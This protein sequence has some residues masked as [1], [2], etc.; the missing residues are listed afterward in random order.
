MQPSI[1][2]LEQKN[3]FIGRHIGPR[4]AQIQAMLRT[5]GAAS[6]DD[7]VAQTVPAAILEKSPPA[8]G[9]PM[10]ES[11]ALQKLA[12]MAR[13]NKIYRSLIGLGYHDTIT[14]NVILRN[15]LQNPGWYTAYTPYQP[16]IS[17]GRLEALITWQQMIMDLTAM[18]LANASLL[19]EGTAAAEAMTLARRVS[20]SPG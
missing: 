10:T 2:E 19:D 1:A 6:L 16:E 5:V 3:D 11:E 20:A 12:E 18:P 4:A 9:E 17:Q 14:P 15:V 7:L 8:I 13:Q